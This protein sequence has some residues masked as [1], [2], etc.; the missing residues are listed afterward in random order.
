MCSTSL[1]FHKHPGNRVTLFP[2][3]KLG[4]KLRWVAF[5]EFL[6]PA[7]DPSVLYSSLPYDKITSS[8]SHI[9]INNNHYFL[10][11]I[12]SLKQKTI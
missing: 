3:F 8:K 1:D 11:S 9:I 6:K 4:R 10:D 12:F 7:V 2:C 5:L